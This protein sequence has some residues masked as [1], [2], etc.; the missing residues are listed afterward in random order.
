MTP[1]DD[2]KDDERI[3]REL[4]DAWGTSVRNQDIEGTVARHASDLVMYD[5][6]APLRAI[7]ISAYRHSWLEQF[8]PWARDGGKFELR[9]IAIT[10]GDRVAFATALIDCAGTEGG[11][12]VE[13]TLRLTLGFEKREGAWTF[14][15][16]HHSQP[17]DF[18]EA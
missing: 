15:H 16:E 10:A 12:R 3:L 5:V 9:D 1:A 17:V 18:D 8:F 7:G 11:R 13:Y 6:V 4:I 14:V 2:R